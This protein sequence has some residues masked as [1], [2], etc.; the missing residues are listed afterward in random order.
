M[1][2]REGW[3]TDPAHQEFDPSGL[4]IYG[5]ADNLLGN[6]HFPSVAFDPPCYGPLV[7]FG[8]KVRWCFSYLCPSNAGYPSKGHGSAT[9]HNDTAC[10]PTGFI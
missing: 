7:P 2:L 5:L 6:G 4:T 3:P 1:S 10:S 8:A 9:A